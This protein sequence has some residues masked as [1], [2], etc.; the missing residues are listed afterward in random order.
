MPLDKLAWMLAVTLACPL[1]IGS[2][3]AIER[4]CEHDLFLPIRGTPEARSNGLARIESRAAAALKS[5]ITSPYFGS[6]SAEYLNSARGDIIN[7]M[8]LSVYSVLSNNSGEASAKARNILLNWADTVTNDQFAAVDVPHGAERAN[9]AGLGLYIGWIGLGAAFSYNILHCNKTLS[10]E[11]DKRIR[12]WLRRISSAVF[13]GRQRWVAS[14]YFGGQIANNHL[15]MHNLAIFTLGAV[16]DDDRMMEWAYDSP[17]NSANFVSLIGQAI[18]SGGEVDGISIDANGRLP[19]RGEIYDRYRMREG[20]GLHY[21]FV[22]LLMF[23]LLAEISS[24]YGRHPYSVVGPNGEKLKDAFIYYG[25]FLAQSHCKLTAPDVVKPTTLSQQ[26]YL[27]A[28]IEPIY[29]N[30]LIP[31]KRQF[32][33]DPQVKPLIDQIYATKCDRPA[34]EYAPVPIIAA[35][36][37]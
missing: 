2:A 24:H 28:R 36:Y 17:K 27:N 33:S 5:H 14:N 6:A 7:A 26:F 31:M 4:Q 9:Y 11:E 20:K 23:G 21:S 19:T 35:L 25:Q 22:Q 18:Y 15:S 10:A 12:G 8:Y 16:L 13:E 29:W 1:L 30:W 3:K 32:R 34:G 37:E